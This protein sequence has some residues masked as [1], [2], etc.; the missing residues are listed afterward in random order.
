MGAKGEKIHNPGQ[1]GGSETNNTSV[2][3][4]D[5]EAGTLDN[6]TQGYKKSE[7]LDIFFKKHGFRVP[8]ETTPSESTLAFVARAHKLKSCEFLPLGR[9]TSATDTRDVGVD[10]VRIKEANGDFLL[11]PSRS[12][13][14]RGADFSTSSESF[15]HAVR[16]LMNSYV[17]VF[18]DD[19]EAVTGCSLQAATRHVTAVE[20]CARACARAKLGVR[21]K[22][23]ECEMEARKEWHRVATA[24]SGLL[25]GDIVE[26]VSQRH[27]IWPTGFELETTPFLGRDQYQYNRDP[28]RKG[29]GGKGKGRGRDQRLMDRRWALKQ[30]STMI[31]KEV[32]EGRNNFLEEET[33]QKEELRGGEGVAGI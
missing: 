20:T 17:L 9:V 24:D 18:G 8:I 21:P 23:L 15:L 33:T 16:I 1:K 7:L 19:D 13:T 6:Q 30:A 10:H 27:S 28:N 25:L 31:K 32:S 5:D 4:R 22:L 29:K 14:R 12:L 3:R 11:G 26:L 2:E